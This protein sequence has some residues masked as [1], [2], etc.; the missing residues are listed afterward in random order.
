[1]RDFPDHAYFGLDVDSDAIAWDEENLS[2]GSFAANGV[3][4]P[5]DFEAGTFGLIISI[6]VF[7][8]IGEALQTAWLKELQRLAR[9]GAVVLATVHAETLIERL[10]PSWQREIRHKGFGFFRQDIMPKGFSS[11]YQVA[12]HTRTYVDAHWS[13]FFEIV[14]HVELDFHDLVVMRNTA[15]A[16]RRTW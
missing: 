12:F 2:S 13:D 10:A 3:D 5:T 6:S 4:P 7:T 1:M 8:H 14:D 9:P 15:G 16:T 11:F